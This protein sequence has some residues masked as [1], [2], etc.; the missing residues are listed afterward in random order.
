MQLRRIP[1]LACNTLN[2]THNMTHHQITN[3]TC[4]PNRGVY[5]LFMIL[6]D[7]LYWDGSLYSIQ[8]ISQIHRVTDSTVPS[9]TQNLSFWV[10]PNIGALGYNSV[11]Y[12][13][14]PALSGLPIPDFRL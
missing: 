5:C 13:A 2:M 4:N 3:L 8:A 10:Y 6:H 9:L 11:L 14:S 7:F 1:V 12:K